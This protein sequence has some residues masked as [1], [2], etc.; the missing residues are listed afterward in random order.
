MLP[1]MNVYTAVNFNQLL[2]IIHAFF[3]C[4][5]ISAGSK[6]VHVFQ[7]LELLSEVHFCVYY[8]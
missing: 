7:A 6:L 2:A 5:L 4:D 3:P 1:Y 8:S